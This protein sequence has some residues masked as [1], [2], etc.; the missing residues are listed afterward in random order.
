MFDLERLGIF[1]SGRS[2]TQ[3][4]DHKR[5]EAKIKDS[6]MDE[7]ACRT[8]ILLQLATDK[9]AKRLPKT[10]IHGIQEY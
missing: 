2:A 4:R 6:S 7:S 5:H 1:E 10:S 8:K 9:S 3:V